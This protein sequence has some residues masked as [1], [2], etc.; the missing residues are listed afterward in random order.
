VKETKTDGY[1]LQFD[2]YTNGWLPI[3]EW[4]RRKL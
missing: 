1:F 4:R 3:S 2:C